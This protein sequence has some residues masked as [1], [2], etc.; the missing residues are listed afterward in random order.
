MSDPGDAVEELFATET[1]AELCV[2]QGRLADAM[3]IFARL[4]VKRAGD[5]RSARWA[6][7]AHPLRSSR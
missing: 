4:L 3:A 5:K 6:E 2:R 1:M 7:R